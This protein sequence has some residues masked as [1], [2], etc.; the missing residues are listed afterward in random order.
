MKKNG[1]SAE[2][3]WACRNPDVEDTLL[4]AA[5]VAD[6][7]VGIDLAM[8]ASSIRVTFGLTIV[9]KRASQPYI[10]IDPDDDV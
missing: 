4:R 1:W 7:S 10:T 2:I 9:I 3:P 5:P 6:V 8:A